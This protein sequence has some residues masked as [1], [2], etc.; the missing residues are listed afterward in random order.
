MH[1]T[2]VLIGFVNRCTVHVNT[3]ITGN[4]QYWNSICHFFVFYIFVFWEVAAVGYHIEGIMIQKLFSW[5]IDLI[6]FSHF[7][8]ICCGQAGCYQMLQGRAMCNLNSEADLECVFYFIVFFHAFGHQTKS[9]IKHLYLLLDTDFLTLLWLHEARL[10]K[11]M[12]CSN[13]HSAIQFAL[14]LLYKSGLEGVVVLPTETSL[15]SDCCL[16]VRLH[17]ETSLKLIL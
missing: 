1:S 16:F 9:I 2:T 17:H 10:Y 15:M 3:F 7:P 8:V 5:I 12:S 14:P 4:I 13:L 6:N 11:L